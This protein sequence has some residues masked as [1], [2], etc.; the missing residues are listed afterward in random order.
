[1][2]VVYALIA[3]GKTVLAEYTATSGNFPTVTR[4]LLSKITSQDSKMSYVYDKHVF[5]YVV[6][7]SITYLCMADEDAKRRIPFAFL[8]DIKNRFKSSY[9]NRAMTAIAFAMNEEFSPVLKKQLEYYNSNPTADNI[10]RVK[11]TIHEVK[12][13]MVHNIEKVL[14]RGEKIELLVDKT[15]RLNQQAF[16]FEKQSKKLKNAMWW[17][18]VKCTIIIVSVSSVV[19]YLILSMFCGFSMKSCKF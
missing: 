13:V 12:D 17:N 19:I 15:D 4:V 18:K 7:S 9:G 1:M 6:E 8:D 14:E 16:K 2:P 3:R 10:G 11:N 5:H